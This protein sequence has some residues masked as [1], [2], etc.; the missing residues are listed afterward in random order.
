MILSKQPPLN[1]LYIDNHLI[2]VAK[3]PGLSTQSESPE[4]PSLLEITRQWIKQKFNKPG[5]VYLG[6]V[7]RLDR[8]VAG[9][10]VFARTSKAASRLSKQLREHA[11]K[12]TYAAIVEGAPQK[13]CDTL[14]HYLR[15]EKTLKATVFPRPTKDAKI[16]ELTYSVKQ[17]LPKKSILEIELITGRFHQI[18]AQLSFIGHPIV[19]DVKY[20]ASTPLPE[21]QIALYSANLTFRHP[22]SNEE[23][24]IECPPPDHF[25]Q[26][27]TF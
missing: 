2:V 24:T 3:P 9:A 20:G 16:A 6:L 4:H 25:S 15:K 27:R 23:I 7:H 22:I 1:V 11:I 21:N 17:L 5:K 19:G 18:R 8:P 14:T 12:K 26:L 13:S 10:I